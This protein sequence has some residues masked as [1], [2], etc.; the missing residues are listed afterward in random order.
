VIELGILLLKESG[1]NAMDLFPCRE[2][3]LKPFKESVEI[4]LPVSGSF[5]SHTGCPAGEKAEYGNEIDPI[6]R[7]CTDAVR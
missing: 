3:L 2:V 5:S 1:G 6:R 7:V 4:D